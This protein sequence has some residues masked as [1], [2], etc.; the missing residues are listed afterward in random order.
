MAIVALV[1]GAGCSSPP[2]L[3]GPPDLAMTND[4]VNH[5]AVCNCTSDGDCSA[6]APHCSDEHHCVICRPSVDG[7]CPKGMACVAAGSGMF[8][9]AHS[10]VAPADCAA[11]GTPGDCCAG[12]C[13]DTM[14]SAANCG[15]CG[16][17]CADPPNGTAACTAGACDVTCT[18][19]FANCNGLV[20]DGCEVATSNDIMNCG[21]C[22]T[23]CTPGSNSVAACGAGKCGA[24][25]VPGFFDCDGNAANG[26]EVDGRHDPKN[27]NGCGTACTAPANAGAN[28]IASACTFA[29]NLGFGNCDGNAANGCEVDVSSD[30]NNCGHCGNAC[31]PLP[32]AAGGCTMGQCSVGNCNNGFG[33]CNHI[34]NDGCETNINSDL[35]N[36][37][38]CGKPCVNPNGTAMCNMGQCQITCNPGF[39]DCNN[40]PTDGCEANLN[41]DPKNCSQCGMVCPMNL[42]Y[43]SMGVCVL[44]PTLVG[45]Y[46]VNAGPSWFNNPPCYTCQ[47]ACAIVFGGQAGSYS[48]S[49]VNNMVTHTAYESGYADGS[50]C[51]A[52][53]FPENFKMNTN[54]NCGAFGCSYSA[55]VADNCFGSINYC[56]R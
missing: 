49:V 46:A 16:H 24:N 12:A 43:C 2:V 39:V 40:D 55:Y 35:K 10:C 56:F 41:N 48:C 20:T 53:P 19:G 4:C 8:T 30:T 18:A 1:I 25:C 36:C 17:A 37:G 3:L 52:N 54:Y 28:C 5:P 22:G 29:C 42:P 33:D 13:I 45:Q 32:N 50:H 14:T 7:D 34:P 11:L 38:G 31:P 44:Q 23:V 47:E 26:C 6:S 21:G 9:C 51:N 27:C 15:S